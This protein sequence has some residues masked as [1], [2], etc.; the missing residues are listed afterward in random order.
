MEL[1]NWEWD[2]VAVELEWAD[3]IDLANKIYEAQDDDGATTTT[4]DLTEAERATVQDMLDTLA[5]R[6]GQEDD[7]DWSPEPVGVEVEAVR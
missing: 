4:I 5:E 1:K 7:G 2:E 6:A 3:G